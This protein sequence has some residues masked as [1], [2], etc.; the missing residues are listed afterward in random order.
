MIASD[1]FDLWLW[2]LRIFRRRR[3]TTL[4]SSSTVDF[5][6]VRADGESRL[7]FTW[8]CTGTSVRDPC[9]MFAGGFARSITSL[10]H[11]ELSSERYG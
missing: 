2:W 10:G 3:R 9:H 11:H 4:V 5:L 8:A 6:Y 1:N 7:G